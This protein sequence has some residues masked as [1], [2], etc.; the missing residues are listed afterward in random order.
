MN[1]SHEH[2]F[3]NPAAI[4]YVV[5]CFASAPGCVG[6]GDPSSVWSWFPGFAWRIEACGA[7]REHLG[8]SFHGSRTFF[9]LVKERLVS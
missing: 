9:A 8:W 6:E 5:Q 7:C 3:M 4:R 2:E 1:G